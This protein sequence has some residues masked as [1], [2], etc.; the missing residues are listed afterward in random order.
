MKRNK[1]GSHE[2]VL[3][4]KLFEDKIELLEEMLDPKMKEQIA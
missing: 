2:V 4:M 3:V 1:S